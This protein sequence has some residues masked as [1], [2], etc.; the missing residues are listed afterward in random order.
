MTITFEPTQSRAIFVGREREIELFEKILDG[1]SE[2]WIIHI[3]GDGGTGKTRLLEQFRNMAE[4]RDKLLVGRG[5]ID[6]YN[7]TNQTGFGL[8]EE[9]TSSIGSDYFRE[10]HTERKYF[11]ESFLKQDSEPDPG[12]RQAAADRVLDAFLEDYRALLITGYRI[13]LFFDTCEEMRSVQD[14]VLNEFI[15][16][17]T[18]TEQELWE[19]EGANGPQT[20][21]SILALAGRRKLELPEPATLLMGLSS[22]SEK[23]VADFWNHDPEVARQLTPKT[24]KELFVRTGGRPLYVA[25]VF[26]WL[27]NGV[28][29]V[30]DLLSLHEPFN[31]TLVSWVRRL[32]PLEKQ[33]ILCMA[34]AWRRV[35]Q[36]LLEVMLSAPKPDVE[37]LIEELRRFSFVKYRPADKSPVDEDVPG[38]IQLHDE[39]RELVRHHVWKSEGKQ[40]QDD[41]LKE[42]IKWYE[43]KLNNEKLIKGEDLPQS[44]RQRALLAERMYYDFHIDFEHGME[45][46]ERLFRNASHHLDLAFCDLLNEEAERFYKHLHPGHQDDLRFRQALTLFRRE[47]YPRAR[48]LWES[49]LRRPNLDKK[50]KATI[51]MQLVELDS[52]TGKP[53]SAILRANECEKQYIELINTAQDEETRLDYKRELGQLYN[54]WGYACRV[55]GNPREAIEFYKKALKRPG[56]D[57]NKARALNNMGYCHF[58]LGE[59]DEARS[60]VGMAM[61]MR[62][63]LRIPYELGL[64]CN[65]MG[66]IMEDS[67]RTQETADLYKKAYEQFN[68]AR[69]DRGQA[70]A[71]MNLGRVERFTNDFDKALEHLN[72]AHRVFERIQDKDNLIQALNELGCTY[73]ERNASGDLELALKNLQL[74]YQNSLTFNRVF[75]QMDSLED[76]ATVYYK[77]VLQDE[78]NAEKHIAAAR[79]AAQDVLDLASRTGALALGDKNKVFIMSKATR[80]LAD[81]DYVEGKYEEAFDRYLESCKT[82][83]M[84]V[85]KGRSSSVFLQRRYE[86]MIDRLQEQ[87]HALDGA[88][89]RL[90]YT[91]RL[92]EKIEKEPQEIQQALEKVKTYLQTT[93][94]AI[95]FLSTNPGGDA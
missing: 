87:I 23:N 36:E 56:A 47:R 65:T 24:I 14:W 20:T 72:K 34:L 28:G 80:L 76:I 52:Y 27:K 90:G 32:N 8:L 94:T 58:Q 18:R 6:F 82:M 4:K 7:T 45:M 35:E 17:I 31:E 92:L 44:D 29:S 93:L 57:K 54:N 67:A 79:K 84:A 64:S 55:K 25:L 30:E 61:N 11:Q 19:I 81:L 1:K 9:I 21:K 62:Q 13:A 43:K 75:Q 41:L 85:Y 88:E 26:D 22:L 10:F 70:L 95:E 86:G 73:R 38:S 50:L 3:P 40:T 59:M 5:L 77:M 74:S 48:E 71:L 78:K 2:K 53:D 33:A 39:M 12:E 68:A 66:M 83:G 46:Y 60:F 15:P 91:K 69:S 49:L 51:L 63:K 16:G 42:V 89:K 37:E